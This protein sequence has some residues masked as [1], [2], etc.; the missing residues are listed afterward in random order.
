MGLDEA[1]LW[2]CDRA[3][4][5]VQASKDGYS[6]KSVPK[7]GIVIRL[8]EGNIKEICVDGENIPFVKR[9]AAGRECFMVVIP[10]GRH[11]LI[12]QR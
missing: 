3:A 10:E 4:S 2:W 9:K 1:C 11:S 7:N 5:S 6:V 12:V 8:P